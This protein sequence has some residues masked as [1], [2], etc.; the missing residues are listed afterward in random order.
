MDSTKYETL[1]HP[2]G[3][4]QYSM[5]IPHY[6]FF[7]IKIQSASFYKFKKYKKINGFVLFRSLIQKIFFKN[8]E[9]G[10][11]KASKFW[12]VADPEFKD[13]FA[14]IAREITLQM[15]NE[16]EFKHFRANYESKPT[17]SNRF[18]F[19]NKFAK[20]MKQEVRIG[21]H[22]QDDVNLFSYASNP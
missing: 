3:A 14:N 15:D 9:H 10:S 19:N 22:Y 7:N 13:I 5:S 17:K 20:P 18:R 2:N 21:N 8:V 11:R 4:G 16:I 6:G 1:H 12:K